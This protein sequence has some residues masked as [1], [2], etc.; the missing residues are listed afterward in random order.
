MTRASAI[1]VLAWL[2]TFLALGSWL[3]IAAYAVSLWAEG[4]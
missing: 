4:R 3:A 2:L 1:N